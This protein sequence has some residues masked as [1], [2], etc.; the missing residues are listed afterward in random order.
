MNVLRGGADKGYASITFNKKG[1]KIASVSSSPDFMLTV[2]DWEMERV[3][4]HSKAF[5]QVCH[6]VYFD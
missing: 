5:G 6:L 3:A 1:D 2:W 4:L